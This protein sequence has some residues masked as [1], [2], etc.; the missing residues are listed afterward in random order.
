MCKTF[1]FHTVGVIDCAVVKV[2]QNLIKSGQDN[3]THAI[4]CMVFKVHVPRLSSDRDNL[5]GSW[6]ISKNRN[7]KIYIVRSYK[8]VT[9]Y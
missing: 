3:E 7:E 9:W 6:E 4:A 2:T 5:D 8:V 1:L